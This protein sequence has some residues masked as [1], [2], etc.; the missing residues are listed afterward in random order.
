MTL[1]VEAG[2][3]P[4]LSEGVRAFAVPTRRLVRSIAVYCREFEVVVN[5]QANT[6]LEHYIAGFYSAPPP[7]DVLAFEG[8]L[9]S[10]GGDGLAPESD[11]S[12]IGTSHFTITRA[13]GP[14]LERTGTIPRL[15][16]VRLVQDLAAQPRQQRLQAIG[17]A[18]DLESGAL[19]GEASARLPRSLDF[20]MDTTQAYHWMRFGGYIKWAQYFVEAIQGASPPEGAL[21]LDL[22]GGSGWMAA[23]L[24]AHLPSCRVLCT[25]IA[26]EALEL[27]RRNSERNGLQVLLAQGDLFEPVAAHGAPL[28]TF[29]NPPQDEGVQSSGEPDAPW[30]GSPEVALAAPTG[31]ATHF[32]ARFCRE[33]RLAP[34]G[35]AWLTADWELLPAVVKICCE[36]GWSVEMP[37]AIR[38]VTNV[39]SALLELRERNSQGPGEDEE[40]VSHAM[41][42]VEAAAEFQS[43]AIG[44]RD[45]A[46]RAQQFRKA[47]E[48]GIVGAQLNLGVAFATG[49]GVEQDDTAA[50][51]WFLKAAM[52]GEANAQ[53]NLGILLMGNADQEAAA[54]FR[55]ASMQGQP[56]GQK[57][58]VSMYVQGRVDPATDPYAPRW[59]RHLAQVRDTQAQ[60]LLAKMYLKGEGVQQSNAEA[61]RWLQRA[62]DDSEGAEAEALLQAAAQLE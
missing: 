29:F 18:L 61:A 43:R 54:L 24:K 4:A 31:D 48:R 23:L 20:A 58:I 53:V 32:H 5:P 27:A 36:S 47:A 57:G 44:A 50:A 30:R 11:V 8:V 16:G 34:G 7:S 38:D 37:E 22:G 9:A 52:A 51:E 25:D 35:V 49:V 62:A 45:A 6:M 17:L 21:V 26:E 19:Q 28:F 60:I 12:S 13:L 2:Q 42:Q 33:A 10:D 1:P 14:W 59:I 46:E 3:R 15:Q 56:M 41:V 39:P 55:R 40:C